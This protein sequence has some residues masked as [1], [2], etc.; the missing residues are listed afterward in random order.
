MVRDP[1]ALR[2]LVLI[3]VVATFF[4]A[5]GERI[6]R[7]T[8]AFDWTGVVPVA[9]YRVDAWVT[10]PTYTA[11]PPVILPG[12]RTGEPVQAARRKPV[13]VPAGSVLVIRSTGERASRRRRQA[14]GSRRPAAKAPRR[15]RPEPRSGASPSAIRAA[16]RCAAS[17]TTT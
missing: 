1:F 15:R 10:P 12:L 14:A 6:K 11:R 3:L 7:I 5:G 13:S 9:N 8:A 4:A 2:A 16:S 17:A